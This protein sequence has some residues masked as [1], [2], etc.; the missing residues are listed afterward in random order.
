MQQKTIYIKSPFRNIIE[1]CKYNIRLFRVN[2]HKREDAL[3]KYLV[4]V[5]LVAFIMYVFVSVIIK[6]NIFTLICCAV[7]VESR[8]DRPAVCLLYCI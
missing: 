3:F 6:K 8:D 4:P 5:F 2:L 7:C 1:T